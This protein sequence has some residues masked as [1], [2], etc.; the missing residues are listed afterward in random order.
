MNEDGND[1][2]ISHELV[3]ELKVRDAMT[4]KLITATPEN[5]LRDIQKLMRENR[6]SGVPILDGDKLV[7][8][9]CL[10]CIINAL[11]KG[12]I[13]ERVKERM[14]KNV[15]TLRDNVSLVRASI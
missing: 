7:G 14:T 6:I 12:Y 3:Y 10:E 9:V 4:T 2:T 11:D 1:L 15:I 8:I 13:E 5:S